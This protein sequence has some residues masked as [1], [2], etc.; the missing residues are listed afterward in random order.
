M[1]GSATA[2]PVFP[3]FIQSGPQKGSVRVIIIIFIH[4]KDSFTL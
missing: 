4:F 1:Q 2:K 3:F